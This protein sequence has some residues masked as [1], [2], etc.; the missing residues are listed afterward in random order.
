MIIKTSTKNSIVN[1]KN[2]NMDYNTYIKSERWKHKRQL[3]LNRMPYC[4]KCG[5]Y[6]DLEGKNMHVHHLTYK[7][8]GAEL[9]SDLQTLCSNC[10]KKQHPR[11][12]VY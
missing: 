8:L 10:H 1:I 3:K 7:R 6:I 4:E 2:N 9:F 12:K 5:Y 11:E